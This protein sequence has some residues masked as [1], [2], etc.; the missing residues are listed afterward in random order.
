[1]T[2]QKHR[3][4]FAI[5]KG[6]TFTDIVALH[7]QYPAACPVHDRYKIAESPRHRQIRY[8]C[9]PALIG[10]SDLRAGWEKLDRC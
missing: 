9:C 3:W 5:D 2:E 4:R 7:L 10:F 6:G 1:M 8:I